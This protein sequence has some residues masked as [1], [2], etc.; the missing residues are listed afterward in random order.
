MKRL[1]ALLLFV[2]VP[3]I[4]APCTRVSTLACPS[5]ANVAA[6]LDSTDC[7]A[8]DGTRYDL[9]EFSGTAGDAVTL[10]LYSTA[11]DPFLMLIDPNDVPVAQNDD[12]F[13]GSTDSRIS[14][15]LTSTGTWT[16]VANN[17]S[18]SGTGSYVLT[19]SCPASTPPGARRRAVKP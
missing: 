11:F 5:A 1:L 13:S 15:T 2:A 9:F 14:F 18:G 3:A 16:V 12:G 8:S 17:V 6:A 7:D 19:M 10:E 4:A